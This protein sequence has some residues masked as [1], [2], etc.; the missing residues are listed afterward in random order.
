[1]PRYIFKFLPSAIEILANNRSDAIQ[2][3]LQMFTVENPLEHFAIE[4]K[5]SFL[6]RIDKMDI[7]SASYSGD[8]GN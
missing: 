8:K 2:D 6:D 7:G 5:D 4:E 3:F 1:M